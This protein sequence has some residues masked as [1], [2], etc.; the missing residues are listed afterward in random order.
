M[1]TR[2]WVGKFGGRLEEHTYEDGT[3]HYSLRGRTGRPFNVEEQNVESIIKK[4]LMKDI[5]KEMVD[6]GWIKQI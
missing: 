6:A 3:K 1:M 4:W 5:T 2:C